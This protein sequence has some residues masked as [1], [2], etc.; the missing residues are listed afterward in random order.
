MTT[1][2]IATLTALVKSWL[3]GDEA[4]GHA[5][6]DLWE[7]GELPLRWHEWNTEIADLLL[8]GANVGEALVTCYRWTNGRKSG[9]KWL[10]QRRGS[11]FN[12]GPAEKTEAAGRT[13]AEAALR[14]ALRGE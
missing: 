3:A 9:W 14:R 8:P 10:L 1:V 4:A 12:R 11:G 6:A 5:L 7:A 2:N 13:A